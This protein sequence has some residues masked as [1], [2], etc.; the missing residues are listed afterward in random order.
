MTP[1]IE[2]M[3]DALHALPDRDLE[4]VAAVFREHS[5]TYLGWP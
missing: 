5:S 2:Q 1:R 4:T 3:I